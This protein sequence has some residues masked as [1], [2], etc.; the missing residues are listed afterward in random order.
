MRNDTTLAI[1]QDGL[2]QIAAAVQ[3]HTGHA[4][5]NA[6]ARA[7]ASEI[8]STWHEGESVCFE[9]SQSKTLTGRPEVVHLAPEGFDITIAAEE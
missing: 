4:I 2:Q 5:T 1:N 6:Q 3:Y 7:W 9:I 8:E